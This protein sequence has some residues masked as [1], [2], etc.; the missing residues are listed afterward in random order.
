M[1]IKKISNKVLSG[2]LYAYTGIHSKDAMH[3]SCALESMCEYFITTDV[4][5]INKKI[6]NIQII[7]P[8]DFV[9]IVE[10]QNEI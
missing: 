9:R 1:Q 7:N 3:I 8:I 4:G 6:D 2:N 10:E 5:L